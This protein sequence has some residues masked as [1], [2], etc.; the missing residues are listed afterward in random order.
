MTRC[1]PLPQRWML[2]DPRLRRHGLV[3]ARHLPPGTAIIVRSDELPHRQR[4][5]LIRA[6]RRIAV[7]RRLWLFLAA[8]PVATAHRLGA[9]GVHLRD[10]SA[11]KA[12]QARRLGLFSSAPVHNRRDAQAVARAD[13]DYALVS[14]LHPTRS[15]IGARGLGNRR[16]LQLARLTNARASALGGMTA[17]CHRALLRRSAR[18][19]A[20]LGWAA[21]DAWE[22]RFQR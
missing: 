21:I 18:R 14:P 13:I 6:L 17:K 19:P 7:A 8:M 1:H 22:K 10:R 2:T 5:I 4:L 9:D 12:A 16:F 11:G 20:D 15:H 3:A